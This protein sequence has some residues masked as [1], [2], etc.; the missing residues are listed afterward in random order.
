MADTKEELQAELQTLLTELQQME[1]E[2]R[3]N[4]D[5]EDGDPLTTTERILLSNSQALVD[6]LRRDI[7]VLQEDYVDIPQTNVRLQ[8]HAPLGGTVGKGGANHENDVR[9]VVRWLN[10]WGYNVANTPDESALATMIEEFQKKQLGS[11]T[12][13]LRMGLIKVGGATWQVLSGNPLDT[14]TLGVAENETEETLLQFQDEFE[15]MR[16]R[17]NPDA[18]EPIYVD[19]QMPY[20][21]NNSI[22]DA[23]KNREENP[24]V[25]QILQSTGIKNARATPNR[26]IN[27]LEESIKAGEV[28]V[29]VNDQAGSIANLRQH[30]IT[31]GVGADCFGVVGQA[32]N[33][34]EQGTHEYAN[35]EDDHF[36][37]WGDQGLGHSYSR[38]YYKEVQLS[39]LRA[40]DVMFLPTEGNAHRHARVITD[41]DRVEGYLLF[42]T[43][44]SSSGGSGH[45]ANSVR[46][47]YDES[48]NFT[49]LRRS[50][51][52]GQNWRPDRTNVQYLRRK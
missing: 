39:E 28:S 3:N 43:V 5:R 37:F 35:Y 25:D 30:L 46:W 45:G 12:R 42:T 23:L 1:T 16:V 51:D 9:L 21:N 41:V 52:G 8:L 38:T 44:E 17:L 26:I 40:D 14:S 13:G 47:R 27:F 36:K 33:Y 11:R 49:Q 32:Y 2:F 6:Q 7:L 22:A 50:D 31:Y 19:V 15:H 24:D 18:A 29:D 10:N 20:V 34:Q 48:D 4:D